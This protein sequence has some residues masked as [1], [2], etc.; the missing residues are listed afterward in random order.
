MEL[1]YKFCVRS[2]FYYQET[3]KD[4]TQDGYYLIKP[5]ISIWTNLIAYRNFIHIIDL[6][7]LVGC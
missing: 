6:L 5:S 4:S 1:I 3:V 7:Q 2:A